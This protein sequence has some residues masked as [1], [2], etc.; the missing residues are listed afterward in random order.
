MAFRV[1]AP[2][3]TAA[4]LPEGG[5]WRQPWMCVLEPLLCLFLLQV[6]KS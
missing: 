5:F 4:I 1:T 3:V 6:A 2:N